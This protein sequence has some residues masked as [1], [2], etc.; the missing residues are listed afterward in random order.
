MCSM[1]QFLKRCCGYSTHIV[2]KW[3]LGFNTVGAL[4]M[5]R[6]FDSHLGIKKQPVYLCQ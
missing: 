3:H 1:L 5:S 6:G 4:P 2:G